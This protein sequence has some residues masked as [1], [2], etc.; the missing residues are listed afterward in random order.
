M[1]PH[2]WLLH[3][4]RPSA[5]LDKRDLEKV[6]KLAEVMK[7]FLRML[8]VALVSACRDAPVLEVYQSDATPLKVTSREE[9]A[10]GGPT[11]KTTFRSG[12]RAMTF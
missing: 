5:C 6:A 1:L 2:Q 9:I 10:S 11:L 4:A 3:F 7:H 12:K 8:A